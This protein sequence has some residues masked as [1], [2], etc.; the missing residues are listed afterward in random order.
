MIISDQ[1]KVHISAK[2]LSFLKAKNIL[3]ETIPAGTTGYLQ[4]LDVSINRPL[5]VYI[6]AKFDCWFRSYG[7][8]EANKTRG[9]KC[10]RPLSYDNLIEWTLEACKE[11]KP[12]T[13][14]LSF[15]TTGNNHLNVDLKNL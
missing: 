3:Y 15:K 2:M 10:L 1:C 8:S 4:P 5:K 12:N 9:G 13:V 11:I 6:K 14:T 7:I